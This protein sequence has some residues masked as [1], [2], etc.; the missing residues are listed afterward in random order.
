MFTGGYRCPGATP[1]NGTP[2]HL[3]R[4]VSTTYCKLAIVAHQNIGA[5]FSI[6][7]SDRT[8]VALQAARRLHGPHALRPLCTFL[9][10]MLQIVY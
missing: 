7:Q 5:L 8:F 10:I 4:R 2:E 9:S 1:L 6:Y 3:F